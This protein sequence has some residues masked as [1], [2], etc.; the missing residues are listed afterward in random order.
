MTQVGM[1]FMGQ[2][3]HVSATMTITM[4]SK[5]VRPSESEKITLLYIVLFN[6]GT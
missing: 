4:G 1:V 5:V 3:T 6:L 2:L